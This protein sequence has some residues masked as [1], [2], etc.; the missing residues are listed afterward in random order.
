MWGG[1][2]DKRT[3]RSVIFDMNKII[4]EYYATSEKQYKEVILKVHEGI[5]DTVI[6][7]PDRL[8]DHEVL[9]IQQNIIVLIEKK[10]SKKIL[11]YYD[12]VNKYWSDIAEEMRKKA[13]IWLSGIGMDSCKKFSN[14][15]IKMLPEK[16]YLKHDFLKNF[17]SFLVFQNYKLLKIV[18]ISFNINTF[19][20]EIT[21][22]SEKDYA[23]IYQ[24]ILRFKQLVISETGDEV[25]LCE[26]WLLLKN[27][28]ISYYSEIWKEHYY[29][30]FDFANKSV[31]EIILDYCKNDV[32]NCVS[33]KEVALLT[34][35]LIDNGYCETTNFIEEFSILGDKILD[36]NEKLE[37]LRFQNKM[38]ANNLV[39]NK[40]ITIDD[41][42]LMTGLE[43]ENFVAQIFLKL[44]YRATV[45]KGSGDQGIDVI[46]EKGGCKIGIQTKCYSGSVSN[47]AIQ[48]VVAGKNYY[49]LD[50]SMV[51]TNSF[52]TNSAIDLAQANET[53]LWDR[54][55][56]KEK[57]DGFNLSSR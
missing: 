30:L 52:F 19:L 53:I 45:T 11:E 5:I 22:E 18:D 37:Q 17:E 14:N 16:V 47:S 27:I 31:D 3:C 33:I 24:D 20:T 6:R 21:S 8:E 54:N 57:I 49:K 48:E 34:Y 50:K 15:F 56:L 38:L 35:Y 39:Q 25:G 41:I 32:I 43:F 7:S 42:D 2:I 4:Y 55:I 23:Q 28:V 29:H 36:T 13:E 10:D 46:V 44:G 40:I 9:I 1:Y 26:V 51:I 12:S